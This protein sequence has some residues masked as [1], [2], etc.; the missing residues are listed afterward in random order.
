VLEVPAPDPP[1]ALRIAF[2]SCNDMARPQRLWD[3]ILALSPQLWVWMGDNIYAD[4]E[5]PARFR[6][7]YEQTLAHPG[8]ARLRRATTVLGTWDDHDYGHDN[9]GSEYPARQLAQRLLLDFLDEPAG[10]PRRKQAGVYAAYDY[11]RGPHK[12]R[13][14][15]LDTRYHRDPPGDG[16]DILGE[17]Q[18]SFLRDK[19]TQSPA[20]V[21]IIGSSIQVLAE[22]HPH[23]KWANFPASRARL[24]SLVRE[25]GA[26]NVV[27]ISGDRHFAELSRLVQAGQPPLYDLTSSS[28]SRPF[29]SP[30]EENPLRVGEVY[31]DVNFGLLEID[32]GARELTL[33]VRGEGNAVYIEER[34]PLEG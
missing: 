24:L 14:I 9:A 15:L 26:H 31:D 29:K 32:W 34:L 2:G 25:S 8:Y 23:E 17:A 10:S 19:L 4:T 30:N 28:L 20:R 3:S 18:W 33:Q 27:F 22:Q 1:P 21:H 13:L 11:G 5:D 12:V 7:L 16:A 6:M